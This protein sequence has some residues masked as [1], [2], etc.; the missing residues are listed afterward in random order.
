MKNE[1]FSRLRFIALYLQE[2][3]SLLHD[4]GTVFVDLEDNVMMV[5]VPLLKV[6]FEIYL[7]T[8]YVQDEP[9]PYFRGQ[10]VDY[11]TRVI[12]HLDAEDIEK[13]LKIIPED[14]RHEVVRHFF[15]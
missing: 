2:H 13:V 7:E 10:I 3:I 14:K 9:F 12:E 15:R 11:D 4:E 1:D 8:G 5:D 6:K